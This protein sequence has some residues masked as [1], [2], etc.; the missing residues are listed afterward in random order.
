MN[1]DEK[2]KRLDFR[3]VSGSSFLFLFVCF[4]FC[5]FLEAAE[6]KAL[7]RVGHD[8]RATSRRQR[9]RLPLARSATSRVD[10]FL[11]GFPH[12]RETGIFS[13]GIYYSRVS[14]SKKI[15]GTWA[16][17]NIDSVL[18][19]DENSRVLDGLLLTDDFCPLLGFR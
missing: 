18:E 15:V 13:V 16:D 10:Q 17:F 9:R 14:P 8:R 5:F 12:R 7:C 4:C 3:A 19:A 1:G 6:C 2:E 11:S